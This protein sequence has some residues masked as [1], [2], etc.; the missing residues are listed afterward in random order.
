ME[1]NIS[2][3]EDVLSWLPIGYMI[4]FPCLV[5]PDNFIEVDG[6]RLSKSEYQDVFD[7]LRGNVVDE[8]ATFV[9]PKKVDLI[10]K[11]S[12]VNATILLKLR[13]A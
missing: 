5:C 3:M 9:L 11:F 4:N 7:V 8:G 12:D 6:Q 1:E 10:K 13:H 2:S